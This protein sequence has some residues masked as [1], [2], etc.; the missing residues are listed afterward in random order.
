[1]AKTL[2]KPHKR[3]HIRAF[4]RFIQRLEEEQSARAPT[5][6]MRREYTRSSGSVSG[7]GNQFKPDDEDNVTIAS[8]RAVC[9]DD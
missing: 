1:M 4:A 2:T 5:I 8:N 9:S 3:S 7:G 6:H